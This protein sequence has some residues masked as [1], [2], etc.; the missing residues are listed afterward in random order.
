VIQFLR[1]QEKIQRAYAVVSVYPGSVRSQLR[2]DG[3]LCMHCEART[4][5]KEC[6]KSV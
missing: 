2:W 4:I 1:V 5:S 3:K 6:A